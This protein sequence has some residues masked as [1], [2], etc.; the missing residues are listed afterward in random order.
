MRKAVAYERVSYIHKREGDE[1]DSYS[2]ETQRQ[3]ITNH[4]MQH[5]FEIVAT[6]SEIHT[7][8]SLG[9]PEFERMVEFLES[10]KDV[11]ALLVYKLDR[12][13]R[14][15][16]DY[17]RLTDVLNVQPISVTEDFPE[18][19]MGRYMQDSMVSI[20]RLYSAQLGKRSSAGMTTKAKSGVYP[21]YAPTGYINKNKNISID[22]VSGPMIREMFVKY[23]R[24]DCSVNDLVTWARDRGLRSRQGN[25]MKK[26][27]IHNILTNPVHV[28]R[29]RW[30]GEVLQGSHEALI[31]EDLF[32]IVQN[33]LSSRGKPRVVRREFPFRGFVRCGYC[34]CQLTAEFKK[35]KYIY[36]RCTESRGKCEQGRYT[37]EQLSKRLLPVLENIRMTREDALELMELVTNDTEQAKEQRR[38]DARHLRS[39]EASIIERIDSMYEDKVDG[40][41]TEEIWLRQNDRQNARLAGIREELAS[42]EEEVLFDPGTAATVLELA[43]RLPELYLR[44]SHEERVRALKV[45]SWNCTLKNDNV[46]P[47]YKEPFAAIAKWQRSSSWLPG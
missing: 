39:E 24:S 28:G 34:G 9:R 42:L 44:K 3:A 38:V 10:H 46:E 32:Q 7:A 36:Y 31:A 23:A 27:A 17:S 15:A 33:R 45:V 20:A 13:S 26:S 30:K 8:F 40:I 1:P 41:I 37:Q 29:F 16:Y 22:P 11:R 2:L 4:A 35:G 14:N 43:Q 18:D 12:L 19:L 21:T 6:F 25:V 47:D 5:D